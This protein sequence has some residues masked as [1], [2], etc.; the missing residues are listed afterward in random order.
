MFKTFFLGV[1][2]GASAV[3]AL[4]YFVPAVDQGRERSIISVQANGGNRESFRVNLPADRILAG[5]AGAAVSVPPGLEWPDYLNLKN[6][7][8]ELFKVRN[9]AER[10]VGIASRIAVSGDRPF[11][12]WA[13]HLPARGT[14]YVLLDSSPTR[15][16][17]RAGTLRAGTRE[18]SELRGSVFERYVTDVEGADE[19]FAGRLELV[20]ALVGPDAPFTEM[21]DD[22]Q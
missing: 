6:T 20:A 10:V 16:G 8:T 19:G 9:E 18:F 11:V 2:L 21:M 15:S 7:Q 4:M 1:V 5:A 14:M 17:T 3:A 13:V 22:P 12:E